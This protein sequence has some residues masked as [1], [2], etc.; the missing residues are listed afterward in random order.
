MCACATIRCARELLAV[1]V[2]FES[3]QLIKNMVERFLVLSHT[4]DSHH[5]LHSFSSSS[6]FTVCHCQWFS[7][8]I[9]FLIL[10]FILVFFSAFFSLQMRFHRLTLL[11]CSVSRSQSTFFNSRDE[12]SFIHFEFNVNTNVCVCECL[13]LNLFLVF[14][15]NFFSPEILLFFQSFVRNESMHARCSSATTTTMLYFVVLNA[16]F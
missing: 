15:I 1:V 16:L 13:S 12:N 10:I 3:F 6:L 2:S 8:F 11:L 5:L 7:L 14:S 9:P 4:A